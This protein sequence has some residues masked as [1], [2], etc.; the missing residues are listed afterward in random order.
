LALW[1]RKASA[2]AKSIENACRRIDV[3]LGASRAGEPVEDLGQTA[4]NELLAAAESFR[5]WL[6]ANRCPD[7]ELHDLALQTAEGY[8]LIAVALQ[9]P[10][11]TDEDTKELVELLERVEGFKGMMLLTVAA[12]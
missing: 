10:N 3:L 6:D 5:V 4:A 11:P 2:P 12:D 8:R 9:E 1:A 7:P